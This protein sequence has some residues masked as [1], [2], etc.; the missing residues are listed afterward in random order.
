MTHHFLFSFP[1]RLAL[2]ASFLTG[3]YDGCEGDEQSGDD[4][5]GAIGCFGGEIDHTC[6]EDEIDT[7]DEGKAVFCDR[8]Y[9]AV[10]MNKSSRLPPRENTLQ[11][12]RR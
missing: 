6:E 5:E 3:R 8:K 4:E 10:S 2:C 7:K 1:F 11:R 12:L 9:S